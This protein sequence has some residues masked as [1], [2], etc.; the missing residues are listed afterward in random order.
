MSRCRNLH[1]WFCFCGCD[2]PHVIPH[3]RDSSC[4]RGPSNTLV[5][6]HHT[7]PLQ[8]GWH[9]KE[10]T[11]AA[12]AHPGWRPRGHPVMPHLQV[13]EFNPQDLH[14]KSWLPRPGSV[15]HELRGRR[16][17]TSLKAQRLHPKKVKCEIVNVSGRRC[18]P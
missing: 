9:S 1:P 8:Q 6:S 15:R 10:N 12:P 11:K 18:R 7:Q 13:P 3:P 2:Q 17:M 16:L 5:C 4:R 14:L